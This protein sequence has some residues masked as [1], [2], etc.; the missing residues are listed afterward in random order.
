MMSFDVSSALLRDAPVI[1]IAGDAADAGERE[2]IDEQ[3]PALFRRLTEQR[4]ACRQCLSAVG[5]ADDVPVGRSKWIGWAITS[6]V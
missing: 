4:R 2:V 3:P 1:T 5:V 6:L